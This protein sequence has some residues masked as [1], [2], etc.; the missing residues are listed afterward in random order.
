MQIL[1]KSLVSQAPLLTSQRDINDVASGTGEG[2]DIARTLVNL[3]NQLQNLL[4]K[5]DAF[6]NTQ[7]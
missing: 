2:A 3:G 1:D 7:R 4:D 5:A 6:L